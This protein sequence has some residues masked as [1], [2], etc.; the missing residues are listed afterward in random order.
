MPKRNRYALTLFTKWSLRYVAYAVVAYGGFALLLSVF[1]AAFGGEEVFGGDVHERA[2]AALGESVLF[3]DSLGV[4]LLENPWLLLSIV[5]VGYLVYLSTLLGT[6]RTT[7]WGV[8]RPQWPA[9]VV[10]SGGCLVGALA[11]SGWLRLG[12]PHAEFAALL[13][14]T[15]GAI[16][17]VHFLGRTMLD[18]RVHHGMSLSIRQRTGWEFAARGSLVVLLYDAAFGLVPPGGIEQLSLR[19]APVAVS[20]SYLGYAGVVD[21]TRERMLTSTGGTSSRRSVATAGG[22]N[23]DRGGAA[24]RSRETGGDEQF[25]P[26]APPELDFDDVAGMADLKERLHDAVVDPLE[27]PEAYR[28]YDLGVVNG[29]LLHGPPGTGKTY[30]SRALAGE[31]G[32][33]YL[34]VT[35]AEI[36]SK[37]VGQAADNVERLFQSAHAHQPCLLFVD[38]FDA[39]AG[40]RDGEM[41]SSERQM[42]NQLLEELSAL[43]EEDVVVV[44]A[45]N[46]VDEIDDAVTRP[47]RFD[48]AIEV[49]RPDADARVAILRSHL[50]R[51]AIAVED[52]DPDAVAAATDGYTASGVALVA[53]RLARDLVDEEGDTVSGDRL[54]AVAEETRGDSV[55]G[56]DAQFIARPPQADFGDVAGLEGVTDRL[57]ETVV[58]PVTDRETYESYGVSTVNGVLLHGPPG[59]GKTLLS[60]ALAGELGFDYIELD[61]AS[62]VSKYVGESAENVADAF[63]V[64]RRNQP[65]VVFIDEIDA[66]AP[67]RDGQMEQ[68]ERRLVN[69]LLEELE[70]IQGEDV[71]VVAA[72]NRPGSVDDAVTR[73][74]RFDERIEVPKPDADGR[75]AILEHHLQDRP[76]QVDGVDVAAAA[77]LT[78]R[79]TGSDMTVVA[80][81]A[82][83][84]AIERDGGEG[85]PLITEDDVARAVEETEPSL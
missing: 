8:E 83:R 3:A 70:A 12:L 50:E 44:A 47:G 82:A 80:E 7:L 54:V 72:T 10:A 9:L 65:S 34:E 85:P 60:R 33:S 74:K 48:E 4:W 15:A 75:A 36:S 37:Y 58:D 29:I 45:T 62:V 56:D 28:R 32:Y 40:S 67:D 64:A 25:E 1:E 84:N 63:E 51:R 6:R 39:L 27:N 19:L 31:L 43:D 30:V 24:T 5:L 79:Y 57:R 21:D 16:G 20:A 46:L 78:E 13:V 18:D 35:P 26:E 81:A 55:S 2:S 17:T 66:I 59:T 23:A 11:T 61:P 14:F 52:V 42:V 71:V 49:P 22:D 68:S 69:Q 38:E 53:E 76:A 73:S 77:E 41:T